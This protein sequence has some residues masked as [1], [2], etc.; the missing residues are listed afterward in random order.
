[1]FSWMNHK[2]RTIKYYFKKLPLSLAL[3]QGI[4]A[5]PGT[6][7][8]SK[9]LFLLS[10]VPGPGFRWIW[11]SGR[12]T[13]LEFKLIPRPNKYPRNQC[14]YFMG[15]V[16]KFSFQNDTNLNSAFLSNMWNCVFSEELTDM[17]S[18]HRISREHGIVESHQ[19][20]HTMFFLEASYLRENSL[21][22]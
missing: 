19:D 13:K 15:R 12:T 16:S 6:E 18:I 9:T 2:T 10:M 17:W 20:I 21:G 14:K 7:F 1:M 5:H 22:Y 8:D 11:E 4:W 3:L